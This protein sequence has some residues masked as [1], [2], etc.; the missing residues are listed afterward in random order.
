MTRIYNQEPSRSIR[1]GVEL[2]SSDGQAEVHRPD[3]DLVHWRTVIW[4]NASVDDTSLGNIT[5]DGRRDDNPAW[6]GWETDS[7]IEQCHNVG[8]RSASDNVRVEGLVIVDRVTSKN[9]VSDCIIVQGVCRFHIHDSSGI[10][11][12]RVGIGCAVYGCEGLIEDCTTD[13]LHYEPNTRGSYPLVSDIEYR[14]I[15]LADRA[16]FTVIMPEYNGNFVGTDIGLAL[17]MH[18]EDGCPPYNLAAEQTG[19]RCE[20][21]RCTAADTTIY[22][23]R[24]LVLD[25]C[26]T[27]PVYVV[28]Q[29]ISRQWD[30][31]QV[32]V[33]NHAFSIADPWITAG[34]GTIVLDTCT[35]DFVVEVRNASGPYDPTPT[36]PLIVTVQGLI[37]PV[38]HY[39]TAIGTYTI[40]EIGG[41]SPTPPP[42][43]P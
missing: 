9:S 17:T 38:T 10:N 21:T 30:G 25:D 34:L 7:G 3:G 19:N 14:N 24:T 4:L 42:Y 27:G 15:T 35:G 32:T 37:T 36:T 16:V 26:D 8:I 39:I 20:L 40:T 43:T 2:W 22:Q 18:I 6:P 12:A 41:I 31:G 1:P 33:K 11:S 28:W 13:Q 5:V 23:P 29:T